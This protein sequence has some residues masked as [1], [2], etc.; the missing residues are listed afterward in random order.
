MKFGVCAGKDRLETVI[1]CGYDFI[2]EH[3]AN[4]GNMTD[5]EFNALV[6]FYEKNGAAV[7]STN[8]FFPG[9]V[10]LYGE[11]AFDAVKSWIS[12]AL[13]RAARLGVRVCVLGSGRARNIPDGLSYEDAEKSFVEI[14]R[15]IASAAADYGIKIAIEPLSFS[16]T[17]F[18]NFVRDAVDIAE[19]S[20]CENVGALVDFFHFY[21]NGEKDDGLLCAKGRLFHTHL[22]R[23]NPDR[24]MPEP[25]DLP[26]VKKWA[27]MLK[28]IGYDGALSLEGS[29]KPDF[30]QSVKSTRALLSCFEN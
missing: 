7:Y 16:E 14:V 2:E 28:E 17:N 27:D 23:P 12:V 24:R 19:K 20:G 30:G 10:S 8:G 18:I 5:E 13:P 26:T 11:G 6:S 3:L 22:A 4:I 9:S 15:L 29:F 21:T 25:D 1:N